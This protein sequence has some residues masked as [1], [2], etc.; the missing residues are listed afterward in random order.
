L[1]GRDTAEPADPRA[2]VVAR[3]GWWDGAEVEHPDRVVS[4][5]GD[6]PGKREPATGEGRAGIGRPCGL[7]VQRDRRV[8]V[9]AE[10]APGRARRIEPVRVGHPD[11]SFDVGRVTDRMA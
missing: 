7:L 10:V 1:P 4:V 8:C 5:D 3:A 9:G 11:V 2:S 6:S